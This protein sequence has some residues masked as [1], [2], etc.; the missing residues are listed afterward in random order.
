MI[1]LT[2][3][4]ATVAT[5]PADCPLI[6]LL[7]EVVV[8]GD[9]SRG[10]WGPGEPGVVDPE[11]GDEREEQSEEQSEG[12]ETGVRGLLRRVDRVE[13]DGEAPCSKARAASAARR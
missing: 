1:S 2:P 12:W 13:S 7:V 11:R 6:Q 10:V 4:M 8:P 9:P 3:A 5:L